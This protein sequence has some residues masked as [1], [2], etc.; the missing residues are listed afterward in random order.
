MPENLPLSPSSPPLP[1]LLS[2]LNRSP[3]SVTS[4]HFR[5]FDSIALTNTEENRR[6]YRD[7]LFTAPD[8]DKYISGVIMF[9]ETLT[10][11]TAA[12]VPFVKLLADRGILTGI[13]VDKGLVTLP[14]TEEQWTQGLDGLA[15]RA[16]A[17]YAQGARFAKVR[18]AP[19][20]S[21]SLSKIE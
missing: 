5:Q 12:G 9:E 2:L 7:L 16:K 17:Y 8:I 6:A 21:F 18:R 4:L 10:Q 11:K 20:S 14:G 15:D 13:K 1:H 19:L 3:S